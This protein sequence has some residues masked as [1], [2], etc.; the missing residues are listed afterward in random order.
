MRSKGEIA[1]VV[2]EAWF[3]QIEPWEV[4]PGGDLIVRS[5]GEIDLWWPPGEP[6]TQVEETTAIEEVAQVEEVTEPIVEEATQIE[7][8]LPA[9]FA[10][11]TSFPRFAGPLNVFVGAGITILTMTDC[12]TVNGILGLVRQGKG[13]SLNIYEDRL[14]KQLD[15]NP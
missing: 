14:L 1:E 15:R 10:E 13:G 5:K 3:R 6:V 7:R 4:R 2:P 12:N 8:V 9:Q 11:P